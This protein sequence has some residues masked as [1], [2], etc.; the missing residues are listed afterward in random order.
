MHRVCDEN[1]VVAEGE[2]N[3]DFCNI[4]GMND[5]AAYLWRKAQESGDFDVDDLARF[6]MDEYDVDEATALADAKAVAA[7]WT[8]AEIVEP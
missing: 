1:V 4:I 3:I 8:D 7:Q 6:L 5:T 2:E